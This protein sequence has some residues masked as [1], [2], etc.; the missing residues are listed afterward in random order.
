MRKV[1]VRA[2]AVAARRGQKPSAVAEVNHP[3]EVPAARSRS[4]NDVECAGRL[5]ATRTYHKNQC[6]RA[7]RQGTLI[8]LARRQYCQAFDSLD[9]E[10][11][12]HLARR[13]HQTRACVSECVAL[14]VLL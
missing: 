8:D 4:F 14:I 1:A 11:A 9:E 3:Y 7:C 10:F 6:T 13:V 12:M 2:G 5:V